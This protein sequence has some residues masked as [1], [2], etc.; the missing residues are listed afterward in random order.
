MYDFRSQIAEKPIVNVGSRPVTSR[1][2]SLVTC[3]F[4]EGVS[5]GGYCNEA[6]PVP[7]PNTEVK[8]ICADGTAWAT[9]WESRLPPSL[10][11]ILL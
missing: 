11:P 1:H 2:S 3:H 10:T 5:D 9:A 4:E 6:T 7:I 8:L